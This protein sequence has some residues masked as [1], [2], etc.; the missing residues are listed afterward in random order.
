MD[1]GVVWAFIRE[2][3]LSY[4]KGTLVASER[5]CPDVACWVVSRIFRTLVGGTALTK[6]SAHCAA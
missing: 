3:K 1:N 2:E 5:G 4:K 6:R